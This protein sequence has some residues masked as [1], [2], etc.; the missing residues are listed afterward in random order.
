VL[1]DNNAIKKEANDKKMNDK[2]A[3]FEREA[4]GKTEKG[5]EEK[6][7]GG[8][9]MKVQGGEEEI[10]ESKSE[11]KSELKREDE[12]NVTTKVTT[13]IMTEVATE[14]K[15][16]I[17]GG[18]EGAQNYETY[19]SPD[20]DNPLIAECVRMGMNYFPTP[21]SVPQYL[22]RKIR[23]SFF[24]PTEEEKTWMNLGEREG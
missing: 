7:E 2:K 4:L 1:D 12:T 3:K 11:V 8:E 14:I 16:E 5:E 6:G 23:P 9:V 13:E 15:N 21:D 18:V 20:S 22:N 10:K 24:P 19:V 17:K